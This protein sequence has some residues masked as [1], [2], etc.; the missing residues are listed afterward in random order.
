MAIIKEFQAT[1]PL[2]ELAHLIAEL[3][4]D[5]VSTEEARAIALKR[6]YSFY[7]VT[8]PE[9][10]LPLTIEPYDEQVY[11]KGKENFENFI[12]K[13]F[14]KKDE[15]PC[16]YVYSQIMNRRMQSGIVAVV[17]ID[18]YINDVIKKHE[19]TR[20]DKEIDRMKHID[21]LNAQTG[22]VFCMYRHDEE[23]ENLL[24]EALHIEPECDFISDDGV[25]HIIRVVNKIELIEKIKKSF[26]NTVLYIADGHHRAAAAVKVG[27][28]RREQYKK[29]SHEYFLAA[30]FPHTQ[31]QILPY[32]RVIADLNGLTT[33]EFF[34][35]L[36]MKFE[37]KKTNN[38]Y[39]PQR[40][41][42]CMFIEGNWYL[43][44]PLFSIASDLI[45]SLDVNIL[46]TH[47]L[48]PILGIQNPR[49]DKRIEFVGGSRGIQYLEELI[50]SGSYKVAFSLYPTSVE[51]LMAVSDQGKIM[52]PKSTWFEPKLRC[53]LIVYEM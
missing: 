24:A 5:V 22:L 40:N 53:G 33:A 31:L 2:P 29:G 35:K 28:K 41:T 18:D 27:L 50:I 14:F 6:P 26:L 7:H 36:A 3:P 46:H 10:D 44:H 49:T 20:H 42:F 13:G 48:E 32:N 37:I 21:T 19:L 43:L 11:L 25:E 30:L 17:S 52:P 9:I 1:R 16:I 34:S 8:K 23:K 39:P 12:A 15:T 51:E 47:I 4:Y 38:P 45:D